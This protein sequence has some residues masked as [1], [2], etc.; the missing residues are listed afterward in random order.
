MLIPRTKIT[1]IKHDESLSEIDYNNGKGKQYVF[2]F[3]HSVEIEE[4]FEHLTN[5]CKITLPRNINLDGLPVFNGESQIFSRGD[6]VKIE[7]G[8]YPEIRTVFTGWISFIG[9]TTPIE[10]ECE[11]D[12]FLLKNTPANYP[13]KSKLTIV[14]RSRKKGTL[15][16]RAKVI[17]PEATLKQLLDFILPDDI[18]F[19]CLDVNLG[20]FRCS[21]VSVAKVL[22][23]LLDE[24]GLFST[25]KD[26]KLYVGFQSNAGETN[27]EEFEFERN[28]F[29]DHSLEFQK[30][31]DVQYL[32]KVISIDK[33]NNKTEVTAGDP[34]GPQRTY[35]LY[36]ATKADMQT[37]ADLKLQEVKYTGY[38]GEFTT[39]GEPHVRPGDIAKLVSKKYPERNGN[40]LIP[41]VKR[42]NGV[43]GYRQIISITNKV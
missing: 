23:K 3:C 9:S 15:L 26:R 22:D 37:Y 33:D 19:E 16:K 21:N 10:I 32:V 40:Y 25:F 18:E 20:K 27:T 29:D 36:S 6:Q 38:S 4:S 14:T 43:D 13:D 35:H 30:A 39:F 5:T 1:I 12:M 28:I 8:Y 24:Y 11:D 41:T 17:V 34:D 42:S 31:E 7:M 2:D